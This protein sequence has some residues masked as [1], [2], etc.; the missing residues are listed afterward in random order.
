MDTGQGAQSL[1]QGPGASGPAHLGLAHCAQETENGPREPLACLH[2]RCG[3]EEQERMQNV[4]SPSQWG[5]AR[6]LVPRLVYLG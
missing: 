4:S 1:F 3:W 2:G 5:Q 6:M